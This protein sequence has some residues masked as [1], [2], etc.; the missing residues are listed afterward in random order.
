[1]Q[2]YFSI[3]TTPAPNTWNWTHLSYAVRWMRISGPIFSALI[4]CLLYV[5]GI[6]SF[7]MSKLSE[8]IQSLD[9]LDLTAYRRFVRQGLTNAFLVAGLASVL[10]LFLLEPGFGL[11]T[12]QLSILFTV[13]A[14]IGLMLLLSRIRRKLGI[15]KMAQRQWCLQQ[16]R[17]ARD[18]FKDGRIGQKTLSEILAFL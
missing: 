15:E 11:L 17:T 10:S 5:L 2:T 1:M 4:N 12:I 3:I 16:I 14:T 13:L 8:N 9:L 7:C 6:E 18:Q